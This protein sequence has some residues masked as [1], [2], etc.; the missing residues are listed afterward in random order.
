MK[1]LI[2]AVGD[3]VPEWVTEGCKE[4][5]GRFRKPWALTL[6]EVPAERR[7]QNSDIYKLVRLEGN[8]LLAAV[9]NGW[10]I[11]AFDQRG[12]QHDTDMLAQ[13]LSQWT[14][15]AEKIAFLIGGPDGLSPDVLERANDVWSLSQLTLAHSIARLVIF[16]QFYRAF[17]ILHGMPYH[18]N[19]SFFGRGGR[20]C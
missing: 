11:V 1:L 17:S 18:R 16:E 6:K 3:R 8:R 20:A 5:A 14:D 13:N 19:T 7:S 9:P 12:S 10:R 15:D 2:I 4:Y